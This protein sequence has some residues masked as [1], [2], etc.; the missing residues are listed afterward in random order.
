MD[1]FCQ[2][3]MNPYNLR[4]Q[5]NFEVPYVRTAYNGSESISYLGPKIWDVLP[6]SI[7]EANTFNSF[8]KLIKKIGSLKHFLVDRVRATHLALV[9]L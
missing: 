5:H 7:K 4:I 2:T 8:K 9:L 3:E 6:V 1:L